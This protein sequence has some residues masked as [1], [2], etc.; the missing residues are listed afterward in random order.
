MHY[1]CDHL[2]TKHIMTAAIQNVTDD[3]IS[4]YLMHYYLY[5]FQSLKDCSIFIFAFN[6]SEEMLKFI[7]DT[8]Y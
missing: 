1:V 6:G 7:M 4:L 2:S 8:K 5:Q 3:L